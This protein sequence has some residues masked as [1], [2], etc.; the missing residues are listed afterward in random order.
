MYALPQTISPQQ[1][2]ML[3]FILR[4]PYYI[5]S[6]F[7]LQ[8]FIHIYTPPATCHA[9]C[10]CQ[11]A[12]VLLGVRESIG[13][14]RKLIASRTALQNIRPARRY[15]SQQLSHPTFAQKNLQVPKLPRPKKFK[16]S[17]GS[18]KS[19]KILANFA[20]TK[21]YFNKLCKS[22]KPTHKILADCQKGKKNF[23]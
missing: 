11:T 4:S 13:R 6:V 2:Q 12:G 10:A 7:L 5:I 21:K 20:K 18:T 22:L 1:L 3:N 17:Q 19:P 14:A 16:K 8:T 9:P 15:V 23:D